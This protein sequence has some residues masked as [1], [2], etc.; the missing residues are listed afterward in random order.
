MDGD[1]QTE[2]HVPVGLVGGFKLLDKFTAQ[3]E[4][5][6]RVSET[7]IDKSRL[8]VDKLS[9]IDGN[10]KALKVALGSITSCYKALHELDNQISSI[11]CDINS[12]ENT[13]REL[14]EC[15]SLLG[16]QKEQLECER[17]IR[18]CEGE[19]EAN[20]QKEQIRAELRRDQLMSEHLQRVHDFEMRQQEALDERRLVLE[21]EIEAEKARHMRR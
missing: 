8:V 2:G 12:M 7:N 16:Q 11:C 13:F 6:H 3:W 5:L 17:F 20:V 21:K 10:C 9:R 19:Y 18:Q 4:Q 1:K 14:E 15:L